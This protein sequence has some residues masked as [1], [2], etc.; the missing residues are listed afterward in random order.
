MRNQQLKMFYAFIM[1][2]MIYAVS[3]GAQIVYTDVNPDIVRGC[4]FNGGCDDAYSLDLNKD[5]IVDFVLAPRAIQFSCGCN[6][7]LVF[8][9]TDSAVIISTDQSWMADYGGGLPFNT[10]IDSSLGWKNGLYNMTLLRGKCEPSCGFPHPGTSASFSAATGHWTNVNGKYLALKI[11]AGTD[12]YYGWIK[13]GVTID[14]YLVT[15]KIMEYAYNSTPNQPILAGQTMTTG[16]IENSFASSINLYPNPADDHL[17]IDF[18]SIN[19]KVGVN[20]TDMTGKIMYSTTASETEK[21]EVDT[22]DFAAGIYVVQIQTA[23]VM[24]TKKLVV[25]K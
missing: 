23:D 13:L 18:G 10:L 14:N 17:T 3:A 24:G 19:K 12:F 4:T 20:I 1:A 11:Q 15:I 8:A 16:T 25:E 5:S 6:L 7:D 2:S 9:A 21:I 22:K